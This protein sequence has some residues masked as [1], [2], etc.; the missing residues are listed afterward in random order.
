VPAIGRRTPSHANQVVADRKLCL[1]PAEGLAKATPDVHAGDR[2]PDVPTHTDP[3]PGKPQLV[4]GRVHHEHL[5]GGATTG[6]EDPRELL[7]LADSLMSAEGL[8]LD[9]LGHSGAVIWAVSCRCVAVNRHVSD[10][11]PAW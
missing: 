9:H 2:I 3:Q 8:S 4:R 11:F 6:V 1:V 7:P 5:V 10:R